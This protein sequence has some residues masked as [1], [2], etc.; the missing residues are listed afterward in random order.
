MITEKYKT[1]LKYFLIYSE[2]FQNYTQNPVPFL[3]S[4]LYLYLAKTGPTPRVCTRINS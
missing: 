2:T 1:F 4:A 3:L